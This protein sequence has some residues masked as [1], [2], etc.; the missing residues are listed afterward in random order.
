LLNH[1]Q[2]VAKNF[3]WHVFGSLTM[4]VHLSLLRNRNEDLSDQPRLRESFHKTLCG[5]FLRVAL[6]GKLLNDLALQQLATSHT[7][8][9]RLVEIQFRLDARHFREHRV[10]KLQVGRIAVAEL[11]RNIL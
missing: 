5:S 4:R 9:L 11:V 3:K 1:I 8:N 7:K 2:V 6:I 10:N